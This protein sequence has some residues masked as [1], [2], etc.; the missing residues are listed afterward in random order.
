[1]NQILLKIKI[2]LIVLLSLIIISCDDSL[3]NENN[4]LVENIDTV[5]VNINE[6]GI[7]VDSLNE[8]SDVIKKNQT[9]A[10]ILLPFN[11]DYNTI[12][13]MV[14]ESKDVFDL[15][16]INAGKD[17][18]VYTKN[19]STETPKYFVYSFDKINYIVYDLSDS[20]KINKGQK[21]VK[22]EEKFAEGVITSSLYETLQQQNLSPMLA[23]KLSE[24]LAWQIDFYTIQEGDFFRVLYNEKY[25]DDDFVG[26]GKIKAI[27]FNHK[28]KDFFGFYFNQG[29]EIDYF[30]ENGNSLRKAFLKAPL[31][32]SRISSSF[33]RRRLHPILRR[34]RPHLG[35]D[36]AAASG[37]PVQ[38]VGDG[39]V[40]QASYQGGAGNYVKIKHNGTYTSGYMHLSKYGKG[41][42]KGA[43][44]RQG[45]I[46]GYVGS[47]GLSTGPHLDFRFW[48]NNDLVNYLTIE[49]PPSNPIKEEFRQ[50]FIAQRDS[51]WERIDFNMN[52]KK[53]VLTAN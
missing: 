24:V 51:L 30:D 10:D 38:A 40:I 50:E 41:I 9:L 31:K 44:V 33:S 20:I 29:D 6:F 46:I 12:T 42:K 5:S 17:Y 52:M 43:Y 2:A 3:E 4:D 32:F 26:V 25:V 48:V 16:K 19:D 53:E 11:V 36:H 35:I 47:T 37:T 21:E 1:M 45:D 23:L 13:S 49:F 18:F 28:G 8:Y 22:V 39:T 34:Y 7:V 15:R 14:A 27:Q